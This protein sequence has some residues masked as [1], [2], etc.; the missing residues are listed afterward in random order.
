MTNFIDFIHSE[1][2]L[3]KLDYNS[4]KIFSTKLMVELS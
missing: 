1:L 2:D 3:I 4:Y